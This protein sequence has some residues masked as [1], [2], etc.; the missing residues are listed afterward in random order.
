MKMKDKVK[1][2]TVVDADEL[3]IYMEELEKSDSNE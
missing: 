2:L 1:P 3:A